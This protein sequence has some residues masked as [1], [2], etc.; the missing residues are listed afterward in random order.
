MYRTTKSVILNSMLSQ[1]I[2]ENIIKNVLIL[3]GMLLFYW[4]IQDFFSSA[5]IAENNVGNILV[6]V[7]I[8]IVTACFGAFAFTYEKAF[9]ESPP[10]RYLAHCTTGLLMLIIGLS[11]ICT[12]F[13]IGRLM[14]HY[15]F[16]DWILILLYSSVILYDFWDLLRSQEVN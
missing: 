10:Q 15:F 14:Q 7:S 13:L 1:Y 16:I 4:L 9:M 12:H 8:I 5:E 6:A 2:K 11:I 3:L